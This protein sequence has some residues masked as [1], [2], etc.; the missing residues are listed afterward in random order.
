VIPFFLFL[1]DVTVLVSLDVVGFAPTVATVLAPPNV[2]F[3]PTV[4]NVLAPP[5]VDFASTVD[6][7]VLAPPVV[8]GLIPTVATVDTLTIAPPNVIG[9][10]P[11]VDT[12]FVPPD[13]FVLARSEVAVLVTANITGFPFDRLHIMFGIYIY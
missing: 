7:I 3:A 2:D 9:L 5:N 10:A 13:A 1:V 11:I 6:T 4:A 12:V 8:V